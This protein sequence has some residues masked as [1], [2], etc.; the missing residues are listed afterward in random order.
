MEYT[1]ES[2]LEASMLWSVVPIIFV[3]SEIW[4]IPFF[5]PSAW[6]PWRFCRR[7][8]MLLRELPLL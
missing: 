7:S 8:F 5:S 1:L 6:K 3:L 2:P 4:L